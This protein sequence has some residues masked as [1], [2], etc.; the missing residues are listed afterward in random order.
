LGTGT[1]TVS[2]SNA[3][4]CTVVSA[5]NISIASPF[6]LS[7]THVLPTCNTGGSIDLTVAPVGNYTFLWNNGATSEDIQNLGGGIFQVQVRDASG[8]VQTLRDTLPSALPL[9]V[10]FSV[11]LPTQPFAGDGAISATA[12]N[13]TAPYS[14]VWN[15]GSTSN[16]LL[17]ISSGTYIVTATDAAGCAVVDTIIV[18]SLTSVD[19]PAMI[20]QGLT[21]SPNPAQDYF[22][23]RLQSPISGAFTVRIY[24]ALGRVIYES[25][26]ETTALNLPISVS[27]LPAATYFVQIRTKSQ[28]ETTRKLVIIR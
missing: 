15:T 18:H 28:G 11:T 1:Y 9:Q 27:E 13:G 20:S 25:H 12:N 2:V 10:S 23:I 7:S 21:I 16:A 24:D 5:T 19:A 26:E 22:D 4:G 6:G 17:G 14:Y 8:C 3:S